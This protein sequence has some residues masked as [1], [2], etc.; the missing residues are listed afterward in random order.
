MAEKSINGTVYR[1]EVRTLASEPV[2]V[3]SN[4]F[5]MVI[6]PEWQQIAYPMDAKILNAN[7]SKF[8]LLI[9][10]PQIPPLVLRL[11]TAV[12]IAHFIM[13]EIVVCTSPEVYAGIQVR[14]VRH[15]VT[16]LYDIEEP[17]AAT[18]PI[19]GFDI[20][21]NIEFANCVVEKSKE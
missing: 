6:T 14:Y 16:V 15:N 7:I 8:S 4:T 10:D 19:S 2:T 13:S 21:S 17:G 11:E 5:K 9:N 20:V 18:A 12:A 1:V 3:A